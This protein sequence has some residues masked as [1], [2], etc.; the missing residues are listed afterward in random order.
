MPYHF[1]YPYPFLSPVYYHR[2]WRNLYPSKLDTNGAKDVAYHW[3]I[4]MT[5]DLYFN[6][7]TQCSATDIFN[8]LNK[9]SSIH[10]RS[11]TQPQLSLNTIKRALSTKWARTAIHSLNCNIEFGSART[12]DDIIITHSSKCSSMQPRWYKS[13]FVSIYLSS[14]NRFLLIHC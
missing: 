9:G 2:M 10:T 12:A 3:A 13:T 1:I 14:K 4:A 5:T 6:I 7:S 8:Q 11:S